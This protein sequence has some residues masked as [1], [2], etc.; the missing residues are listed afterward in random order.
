MDTTPT[1]LAFYFRVLG[2]FF[3]LVAPGHPLGTRFILHSRELQADALMCMEWKFGFLSRWIIVLQK[4][5]FCNQGSAFSFSFQA[6]LLNIESGYQAWYSSYSS[7]HSYPCQCGSQL[8]I[9]EFVDKRV[10][11]SSLHCLSNF[12]TLESTRS[13]SVGNL[14]YYL[15]P[16]Y[17]VDKL[18]P[19]GPMGLN[20]FNPP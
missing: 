19:H 15:L 3:A 10:T 1:H 13:G 16:A 2:Y 17:S 11:S 18:L 14:P 6:S 5:N 9:T 12:Q 8:S 7:I 4:L 20:G